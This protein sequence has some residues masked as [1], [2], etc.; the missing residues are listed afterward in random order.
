MTNDIP[1]LNNAQGFDYIKFG[2][3]DYLIS[4]NPPTYSNFVV[5]YDRDDNLLVDQEILNQ[6][7][8]RVV[9]CI[10]FSEL[11]QVYQRYYGKLLSVK[12]IR[13]THLDKDSWASIYCT[14]LNWIYMIK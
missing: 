2:I 14:I 3:R 8:G 9:A 1:I 13:D 4:T 7:V 6:Y 11:G 12:K 10:F 5:A